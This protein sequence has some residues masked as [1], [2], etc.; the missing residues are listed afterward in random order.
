MIELHFTK[1]DFEIDWFNGTGCGGQYRNKTANCCRITHKATGLRAQATRER[2]R[3][4]NQREAF[5]RLVQM[6][7]AHY[8]VKQERVI[9]DET[10]R[11]YHA[12]RNEVK[13][14]AS[15]LTLPY[16]NVVDKGDLSEMI[17]A[18]AKAKRLEQLSA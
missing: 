16:R 14:L 9:S 13:D 4:D 3:V 11:N 10:I 8:T 2:S 1:K 6:L 18:R 5:K 12:C 7:I 15:G 17:E